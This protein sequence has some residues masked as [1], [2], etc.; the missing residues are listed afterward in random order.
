MRIR[1]KLDFVSF[2]KRKECRLHARN[3]CQFHQF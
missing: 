1:D 2:L 3:M